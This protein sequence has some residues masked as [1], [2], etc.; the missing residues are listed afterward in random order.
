MD[1]FVFILN[2]QWSLFISVDYCRYA[3]SP[4]SE[5]FSW[6]SDWLPELS[7]GDESTQFQAGDEHLFWPTAYCEHL[8]G[9]W[10]VQSG[11]TGFKII[12]TFPI[13]TFQLTI[14]LR[15]YVSIT[16]ER[17]EVIFQGTSS[18][19]PKDPEAVWEEYQFRCKPGDVYRRPCLISPYHYRL[20]WLM[21]FA[22]FQ[23]SFKSKKNKQIT[24][25][26]TVSFVPEEHGIMTHC[27]LKGEW[28]MDLLG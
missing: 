3:D 25:I 1:L 16:K 14:Y 27:T 11:G 12:L 22:A 19:D 24:R 10:Q 7:C 17:T 5:H 21:W 23:V 15:L 20:D 4:R 8:R 2:K 6:H 28:R 13:S 26:W 9:L 18:Q